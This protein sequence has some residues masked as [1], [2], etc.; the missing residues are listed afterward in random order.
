MIRYKAGE[1]IEFLAGCWGGQELPWRRVM[2]GIGWAVGSILALAG[3]AAWAPCPAIAQDNSAAHQNLDR[4]LD[5]LSKNGLFRVR[6]G[7][8]VDPIPLNEIHSWSLN[9][10]DA[11]GQPVSGAVIQFDGGMPE[12]GHGLP[13]A[14]RVE[15]GTAPGEYVIRGVKFSMTG[16]WELRLAISANGQTDNATFNLVL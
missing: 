3:A 10:S 15:P 13:T 6:I 4:S 9:L 14:P 12:H 8:T 2:R 5:R 11:S 7:S 1:A 16:W